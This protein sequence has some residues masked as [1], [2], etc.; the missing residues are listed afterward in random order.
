V[1]TLFLLLLGAAG[2]ELG[3][4]GCQLAV[5]DRTLQLGLEAVFQ[6]RIR[7]KMATLDLY[8]I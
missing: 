1:P 4:L 5:A 3:S 7:I 8:P 2:P 6:I